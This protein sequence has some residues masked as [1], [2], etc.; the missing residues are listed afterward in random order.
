MTGIILINAA[1]G[2]V[3]LTA[4]VSLVAWAIKTQHRDL[5]AIAST[6]GTRRGGRAQGRVATRRELAHRLG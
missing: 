5:P 6:G 2:A 4:I 1:L 3:A